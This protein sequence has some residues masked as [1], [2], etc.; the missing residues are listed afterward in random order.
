[1]KTEYLVPLF[2]LQE[3]W[4]PS[5]KEYSGLQ[6]LFGGTY[7]SSGLLSEIYSF[8]FFRK[9]KGFVTVPGG[10]PPTYSGS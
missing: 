5:G 6:V 8:T 1:M 2:E 10:S 9:I 4:L 3:A 7:K